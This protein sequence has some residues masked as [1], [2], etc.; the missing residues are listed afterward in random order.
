MGNYF[1]SKQRISKESKYIIS[2]GN[3][4]KS[5]SIRNYTLACELGY[6][7]SSELRIP[8]KQF[9]EDEYACAFLLPKDIF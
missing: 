7:I 5:A 6:I 3:D 1:Y 9:S 4:K 2:L 8:N